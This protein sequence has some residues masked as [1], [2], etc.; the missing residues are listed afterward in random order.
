MVQGNFIGTDVSGTT[1]LGNRD[2]VYIQSSNG[3]TIGGTTA[4][5]RN[6]ISGNNRDGVDTSSARIPMP[7]RAITSA[8]TRAAT[9]RSGMPPGVD[10]Q[11]G[12]FNVIGVDASNNPAAGN[13]ISGNGD[14]GVWNH[15][16]AQLTTWS[17]AT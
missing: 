16:R 3:N 10:I 9:W 5:A 17:P 6:V 7:C 12:Q 2:G 13:V 8:W 1:A 14:Y 4:G 15:G 11:G